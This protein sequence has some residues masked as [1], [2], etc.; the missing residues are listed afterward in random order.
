MSNALFVEEFSTLA[1][2]LAVP[3]GNLLIVGDFN[4]H[5]DNP[6]N[7]D[8]I[9]FNSILESFNLKRDVRGHTHKKGHTLDLSITRVDDDLVT[10][11][12]IEIR[13]FVLSDHLA[14]HCKLRLWKLPLE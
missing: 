1:E 6:R 12:S 13:D 10:M 5:V 14:V 9:K 3:P 7:T 8:P 4:F 2:Q 11:A